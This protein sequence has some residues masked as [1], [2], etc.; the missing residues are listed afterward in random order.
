MRRDHANP[1]S[2]EKSAKIEANQKIAAGDRVAV[3]EEKRTATG[4]KIVQAGLL[5]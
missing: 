4:I 5:C 2:S 1:D 3:E